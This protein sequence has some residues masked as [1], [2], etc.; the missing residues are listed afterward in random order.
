MTIATTHAL[1][2][3]VQQIVLR[4][5]Q[6]AG[7]MGAEQGAGGP[8]WEAKF[9]FARD[10][11]QTMLDDLGT[12][13]NFARAIEMELVTLTPGV[14]VYTLPS[15]IYDLVED[16]SYIAAGQDVLA[17]SGE[18]PVKQ[19]DRE[20][21]QR[22]S[23][24]N[25]EGMPVMFW[26]K[27]DT[28]PIQAYVWPTPSEAGTIRFQGHRLLADVSPGTVTVD[29]ERFWVSYLVWRLAYHLAVA[30]SLDEGR[31]GM[32]KMESEEKLRK[33]KGAANQSVPNQIVLNHASGWSWYR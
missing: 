19:I 5:F 9:S 15:T 30:N 24:K 20:Q 23:A 10:I 1:T 26:T 29:L 27:R 7:L 3:N 13:G 8:T 2:M 11:L 31:C 32:L 21:W 12:E 4:A 17:A 25:A 28:F 18:T 16:G 6:T 33:A 22:L 14:Y